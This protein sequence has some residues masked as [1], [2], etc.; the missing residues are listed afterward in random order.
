MNPLL[1]KALD[2]RSAVQ[3]MFTPEPKYYSV[4]FLVLFGLLLLG[5]GINQLSLPPS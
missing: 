5:F 3:L 4:Y 1:R 2:T